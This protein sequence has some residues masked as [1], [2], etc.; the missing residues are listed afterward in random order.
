MRRALAAIALALCLA[1]PAAAAS[2]C[3]REPSLSRALHQAL[4]QAQQQMEKKNPAQAARDLARYAAQNPREAH[5]QLSF[6]RGVLAYQ[7][8]DKK[9][10]E[11][12]FAQAVQLWPCFVPA[13]RNLALL[14]FE[15]KRPAQAIDLALR[16]YRL[17]KPPRPG[18]LYEAAVFAM[19]AGQTGRALP[20]LQELAAR[21]QP[22]EQWLS[23]LL[24]AHM[25]LKNYPQAQAVLERLLAAHPGQVRYWRLAAS[26]ASLQERWAPAA[27]A[28]E[29]AYRLQPPEAQDWRQLADLYRAAGVPQQAARCY[30]QAWGPQVKEPQQMDTL[31]QVYGQGSYAQQ[32]LAWAL[33]AAR[34]QPTAPRWALVGRLL[35]EAKRYPAA[36]AAYQ[37]AAALADPQGRHSLLAGY[38]AWQAERLELAQAA[39]A[40]ALERAPARSAT[41]RDAARA[42]KDLEAARRAA[43]QAQAG[44]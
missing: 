30:L 4:Y 32:A 2:D 21:P 11:A 44:G 37:K 10:A 34:A 39:F 16:A 5:H 9:A 43:R 29:V 23:A 1:A 15:Q 17:V 14:H 26:L 13:L 27:A 22:Q 24:R 40:R 20:W 12:F 28:L 18:L 6:L 41:A 8:G 38:A 7:A 19:S 33:R 35:L 42:L 36:H 25:E 3:P 31:A